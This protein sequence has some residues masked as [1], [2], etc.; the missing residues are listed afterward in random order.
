MR[1]RLSLEGRSRRMGLEAIACIEKHA[2]RGRQAFGI[3]DLLQTNIAHYLQVLGETELALTYRLCLPVMLCLTLAACAPAAQP[4]PAPT[5]TSA[6]AQ[7]T[8]QPSTP[9]PAATPT[10]ASA[11]A[12][13]TAANVV[14]DVWPSNPTPPLGSVVVIRGYPIVPPTGFCRMVLASWP[15][16]GG[17]VTGHEPIVYGCALFS[18][19]VKGYIPGEF[20]PVTLTFIYDSV[21]YTA[22]TGFTPR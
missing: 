20:V 12:S 6:S 2:A 14:V 11:S 8:A 22:H 9:A 21:E 16:Q 3:D 13:P 18:I 19:E 10:A 15:T 5:P 7:A 4:L 1:V 17:T